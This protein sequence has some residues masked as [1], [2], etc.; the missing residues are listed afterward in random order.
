VRLVIGQRG[1]LAEQTGKGS[2]QTLQQ[3]HEQASFAFAQ[4]NC[5][6]LRQTQD[7]LTP[8][9][10]Q[11]ADPDRA[12][13][14]VGASGSWERSSDCLMVPD[15][16]EQLPLPLPSQTQRELDSAI[17]GAAPPTTEHS[18]HAQGARQHLKDEKQGHS[19]GDH[20]SRQ[21]AAWHQERARSCAGNSASGQTS[22]ASPTAQ[23]GSGSGSPGSL[24]DGGRVGRVA[25]PGLPAALL[26]DSQR[27]S[28]SPKKCK[29]QA[30][31]L[32]QACISHAEGDGGSGNRSPARA[33]CLG[34]GHGRPSKGDT[35]SQQPPV[36]Q[37][38][39]LCP[40]LLQLPRGDPSQRAQPDQD[41]Q[42]MQTAVDGLLH[43]SGQTCTV[44]QQRQAVEHFCASQDATH[45]VS[46]SF[47]IKWLRTVRLLSRI[48][49]RL[50]VPS[51]K[52]DASPRS[53][54]E[55][56]APP[57]EHQAAACAIV[58]GVATSLPEPP[59]SPRAAPAAVIQAVMGSKR[60]RE[61]SMECGHSALGRQRSAS[62]PQADKQPRKRLDT[63]RRDA[64][65]P[66]AADHRTEAEAP[67]AQRH[68]TGDIRCSAAEALLPHYEKI[69]NAG[70]GGRWCGFEAS[71][72]RSLR[73]SASRRAASGDAYVPPDCS[74]DMD[75]SVG[76]PAGLVQIL[77]GH[78]THRQ[79]QQQQE[80]EVLC[81]PA[82]QPQRSQLLASQAPQ[83]LASTEDGQGQGTGT[84]EAGGYRNLV[85]HHTG[86]ER[87]HL[88]HEQSSGGGTEGCVCPPDVQ[89]MAIPGRSSKV[90]ETGPP[91]GS[92]RVARS[93]DAGGALGWAAGSQGAG[94]VQVGTGGRAAGSQGGGA[95]QVGTGGRGSQ[96]AGEVRLC[97]QLGTEEDADDPLCGQPMPGQTSSSGLQQGDQSC[98]L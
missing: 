83:L 45:E 76:S 26:I 66:T 39:P 15:S 28:N 31:H 61:L 67:V 4:P 49:R 12:A 9:L 57:S 29:G 7:Q 96:D 38:S 73:Q 27:G 16:E 11:W 91:R 95:E 52:Q 64:A 2:L 36:S 92:S 3:G 62:E 46:V 85:Q 98:N 48:A 5:S 58:Q 22:S 34:A 23:P 50:Q 60:A 19:S 70:S 88:L 33:G 78:A 97:L 71:L 94:V 21:S 72:R 30:S 25:G 14:R 68:S 43:D 42:P 75:V 77:H 84:H 37:A 8:A 32:S 53:M 35:G 40:M 80:Q 56:I 86:E 20:Q 69:E 79:C 41:A 65:Q 51:E 89:G 54:T 81:S 90:E 93:Q 24:A 17:A 1:T 18:G 87:Y 6:Q 10:P 59:G 63:G 74:S 47:A 55:D 82:R 44:A 13:E